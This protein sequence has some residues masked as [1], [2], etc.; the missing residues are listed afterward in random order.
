VI[1]LLQAATPPNV[2]VGVTDLAPFDD[3]RKQIEARVADGLN[4]GLGFVYTAPDVASTPADSFPWANSI[5]VVAVPYLRSG[6]GDDGSSERSV[7]RFADGDRY[8]LVRSAL[9]SLQSILESNGARCEQVYDDDRLVDRAVAIRAGVAWP[10]KSTMAL[11][12]GA[13][14]WFLIG[15]VVTD[16]RIDPTEPMARSCGTC[17]ACMPACPTGA[18]IAPGVL[19]ARLCLAAVL[20]RPGPIPVAL[21]TA[22]GGR[23]YG[24]DDCLVACPPGDKALESVG[25]GAD[26][27]TPRQVLEQTDTEIEALARHWYVPKRN[28]RFV[29]RNAIV[30]LGN[31]G[32][33]ED[34]PLLAG[35]LG[36]PDELL[37]THAAWAVNAIGGEGAEAI[38]DE[39]GR[40]S[41]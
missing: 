6:D 24:C 11:T 23:I 27:P 7:A 5:V 8:D 37:A 14:P 16:A 29:R 2:R 26:L 4:G 35:Y 28:M 19:D 21:R 34:I 30:A 31:T 32:G 9:D 41:Q 25:V 12:P 38:L 3:A 39:E 13:G 1:D 36:H 20:Q 17:T 22:I 18:I 15:S 10:G 33:P 40:A